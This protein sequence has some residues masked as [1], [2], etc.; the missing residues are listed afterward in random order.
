QQKGVDVAARKDR[1]AAADRVS[2]I[3]D[4]ALTHVVE[5]DERRQPAVVKLLVEF[6]FLLND[7]DVARAQRVD[8]L[9]AAQQADVMN[10]ESLVG[11]FEFVLELRGG[12]G[13]GGGEDFFGGAFVAFA[14]AARDANLV[15]EQQVSGVRRRAR[16]ISRQR[17]KRFNPGRRRRDGKR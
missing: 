14:G 3:D 8:G 2:V 7:F 1:V 17:R 11:G 4:V 15:V 16:R 9:A 5:H 13:G 10:D 12:G 6:V